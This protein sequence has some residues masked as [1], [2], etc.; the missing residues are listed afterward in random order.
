MD[1]IIN[2]LQQ[3]SSV[4]KSPMKN[5]PGKRQSAL[6]KVYLEKKREE[7]QKLSVEHNHVL[8]QC[9]MLK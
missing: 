5:D 8:R 1:L 9:E 4:S 7:F 3:R 6:D 2:L